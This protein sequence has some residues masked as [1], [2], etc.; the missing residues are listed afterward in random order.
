MESVTAPR[1]KSQGD[2]SG[3]EK[4]HC[5]FSQCEFSHCNCS[6]FS[7]TPNSGIHSFGPREH[8]QAI[9]SQPS[10]TPNFPP[11]RGPGMADSDAAK[12]SG[13]N[14][15]NPYALTVIEQQVID[16]LM[17]GLTGEEVGDLLGIDRR[18]GDPA[19]SLQRHAANTARATAS[20]CS[21]WS[22]SKPGAPPAA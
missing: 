20:I 21:I 14:P 15:E 7:S 6:Q 4:L 11:L 1:E 8:S 17:A 22:A 9:F 13:F 12:S 10:G 3:A 16:L 18:Q 5:D 19:P 2:F